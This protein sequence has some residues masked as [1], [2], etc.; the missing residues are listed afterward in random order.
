MAAK[1]LVVSSFHHCHI[2]SGG[3][4]GKEMDS[5]EA[6]PSLYI[7]NCRLAASKELWQAFLWDGVVSRDSVAV[8]DCRASS[9]CPEAVETSAVGEPWWSTPGALGYADDGPRAVE[10]QGSVLVMGARQDDEERDPDDNLCFGNAIR[11]R[12]GE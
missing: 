10:V 9:C 7:S 11:A 1:H 2:P 6:L 3:L 12:R 4:E 5:E 8:E